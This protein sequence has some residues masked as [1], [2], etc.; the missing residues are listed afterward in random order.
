MRPLPSSL[1]LLLVLVVATVTVTCERYEPPPTPVLVGLREGILPDSRAPI[2]IDFGQAIDPATLS[3][4][5]AAFE[6]S[7]EGDLPDEDA[8]PATELRVLV[9]HD[10][11]G[12]RGARAALSADRTRLVLV[13]DA[14]MPVG[15]KLVLLVEPDLAG[16]GGRTRRNRT[17]IPFSYAVRCTPGARGTRLTSG[18]YFLLL[19]VEQPLGSQ[20]QLFGALDVDPETGGV[21]ARFTNADRNPDRARCPT[22][23]GE[24]DT[25]RLLP[26]PA[27]VAPSTGA[28]RVDEHPDWLPNPTPPRG[29]SFPVEGCAVDD[30]NGAGL[31]TAPATMVVE[32]PPVTV[33]GLTMTAFFGPD[34]SGGLRA[35]GALVPDQVLLGGNPIGPGKGSMTAIF[36]P[37]GSVPPGVPLPPGRGA[38]AGTP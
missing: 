32:S 34:G 19:E 4:K 36:L 6:T 29:Y 37:D 2:E 11:T 24:I 1:L 38:G 17:R 12:D 9:S 30:G 31:V 7:L 13:P 5:V 25:C 15:P 35:T 18:V 3:V 8:D 10:P 33:T 23:C 27:C 28:G 22:P 21:L 26:S 14:A 16:T 20:I